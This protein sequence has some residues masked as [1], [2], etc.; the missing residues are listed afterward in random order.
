MPYTLK[1]DPGI[2]Q[3]NE[4]IEVPDLRSQGSERLVVRAEPQRKGELVGGML[5]TT[6]GGLAVATGTVLTSVGC[7][8][9]DSTMCT[10]GLV[11]LP[12]GLGMLA[13]G[14]WMMVDSKGVV[15]VTPMGPEA[16]TASLSP[17]AWT[18]PVGL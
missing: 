3:R 9:K 5:V 13:P 8:G 18:L 16:P 12:I 17:L 14:I 4:Y 7:A 10:A 6:F 15:R 2:L 1:Y 11:T